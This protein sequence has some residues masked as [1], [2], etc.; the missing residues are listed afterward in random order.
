MEE[1]EHEENEILVLVDEDGEEHQFELIA[2]LEID[3]QLYV[4]VAPLEGGSCGEEHED[5]DDEE[6]VEINILKAS[7]DE[8][9]NM[10]LSEIEDDE[11]WEMVA[12]AWEELSESEDMQ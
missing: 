11:E 6:E 5:E 12:D 4:V 10:F 8:E 1:F 9:G 3:E 7:Y 2:E